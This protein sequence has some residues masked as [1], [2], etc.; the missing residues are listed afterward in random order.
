MQQ[1]RV[2][3]DAVLRGNTPTER[4]NK[5]SANAFSTTS[6]PKTCIITRDLVN[7]AVY[8]LSLRR[9]WTAVGS[10][11]YLIAMTYT[12]GQLR[13]QVAEFAP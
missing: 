5:Q 2:L 10:I 11:K 1:Q 7:R 12:M 13:P 6:T 9:G 4:S 3:I 8:L